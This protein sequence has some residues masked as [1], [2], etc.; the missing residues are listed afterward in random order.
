[1]V[2]MRF[3]PIVFVDDVSSKNPIHLSAIPRPHAALILAGI[4][5]VFSA[6]S[7]AI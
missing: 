1:M 3:V 2:S 6:D 7:T 4:Y 5:L